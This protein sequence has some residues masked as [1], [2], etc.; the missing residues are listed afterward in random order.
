[1]T[2][3]LTIHYLLFPYSL[4]PFLYL[5][6]L[7]SLSF[8]CFSSLFKGLLPLFS[9]L[10]LFPPKYLRYVFSYHYKCFC[11]FPFPVFF[12]TFSLLV[13]TFSTHAFDS[14][15]FSFCSTR[16]F[17]KSNLFRNFWQICSVAWYQLSLVPLVKP[18]LRRILTRIQRTWV[19]VQFW[20]QLAF[21]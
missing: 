9:T 20:P 2:S 12:F 1:M 8:S 4:L 10:F 16:S 6:W 14:P 19:W 7:I 15:S 5:H 17:N 11:K 21:L 18:D 3:K 13:F